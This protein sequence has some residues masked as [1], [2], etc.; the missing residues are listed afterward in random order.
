VAK[1]FLI[2]YTF[3]HKK[4]NFLEAVSRHGK[5]QSPKYTSI[6]NRFNN[7]ISQ[8]NTKEALAI[9]QF[10]TTLVHNQPIYH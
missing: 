10:A 8:L 9:K 4:L 1:K 2:V 6:S 7:L 5:K 3:T